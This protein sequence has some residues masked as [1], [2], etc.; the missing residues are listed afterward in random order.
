VSVQIERSVAARG[1][2]RLCHFTP[3]RNLLHI[4]AGRVGVLST[5]ALEKEERA[6]F[7]ATDIARLDGQKGHICCSIEYPNAWYFDK[8][9]AQ[10]DIFPDW[11]VLLVDPKYLW[12]AG[13]LFSPRNAA[14]EYGR[15]IA[16][17][18]NAFE[19][20]FADEVVG[21][22]RNVYRRTAN[23]FPACPTDQQAE[24]LV[25]D[26]ILMGDILGVA[27]KDDEQGLTERARLRASGL[28]PDMFRYFS[29]PHMFKKYELDQAIKSGKRLPE[30]FVVPPQKVRGA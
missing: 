3:S 1:I 21:T 25:P 10:N 6:A 20:M 30:T 22:R 12:Q 26:R 7:N 28:D 24:V 17:G 4:A 23:Q 15:Y 11:V 14:A 16:E 19:A 9:R 29:A 18:V 5:S 2:S 27:V 13:T 8:A